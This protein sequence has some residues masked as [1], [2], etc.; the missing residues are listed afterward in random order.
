M[1]NG[2]EG[3]DDS[4]KSKVRE[5]QD[6]QTDS[7]ELTNRT[8][9]M[10]PA[11][12]TSKWDTSFELVPIDASHHE[13]REGSSH[14]D[15]FVVGEWEIR[16]EIWLDLRA[17]RYQSA[18]KLVAMSLGLPPVIGLRKYLLDYGKHQDA[19]A[20]VRR[21]NIVLN[22]LTP[23]SE[24]GRLQ[25]DTN[26]D[27]RAFDA[28]PEKSPINRRVD[29]VEFVEFLEQHKIGMPERLKQIAIEIIDDD[30]QLESDALKWLQRMMERCGPGTRPPTVT[31]WLKSLSRVA[32][33][34]AIKTS[35]SSEI[36][37]SQMAKNA[38]LPALKYSNIENICREAGFKTEDKTCRNAIEFAIS[39]LGV[40]EVRNA[41]KSR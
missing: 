20:Y 21:K 17:S 36:E 33:S 40:D 5:A 30:S 10:P 35:A 34:L 28:N 39:V 6:G 32:I 9:I 4:Q 31:K 2:L 38:S 27:T 22:N 41:M 18:W 1:A 8:K 29:V 15:L 26:A 23:E 25:Y 3:S 19:E 12:S 16:E 11:E 7:S 37:P 24:F 14:Q 13:E